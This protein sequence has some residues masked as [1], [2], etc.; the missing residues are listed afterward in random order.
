MSILLQ[1]LNFFFFFFFFFF[2]KKIFLFTKTGEIFFWA[3]QL[4]T[5]LAT[6]WTGNKFFFKGG[7]IVIWR[8][9]VC[10]SAAEYKTMT[11]VNITTC[12]VV[13]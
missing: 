10:K 13:D 2:L 5:I 12:C 11:N 1:N 3:A 9:S 8:D 6:C 4:V 7:L